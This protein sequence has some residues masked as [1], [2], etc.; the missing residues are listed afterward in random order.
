MPRPSPVRVPPRR[1]CTPPAGLAAAFAAAALAGCGASHQPELSQKPSFVGAVTTTTY[2]GSTDDLL[3]GGL[4]RVG[5][6][7]ANVPQV[8]TPPKASE[9]RRL[10][11]YTNYRALVDT[12]QAGGYGVL[13]GPNVDI[14]GVAGSSDGRIPGVEYRAY[15]DDGTGQRNV[16]MVTQV[17]GSFDTSAPCLLAVASPGSRG[18][19][20]GI[21]V[22]EWGL[23]HGCAVVL[24]D[25]GTGAA[26]HDLHGDTV[27][28]VDGTRESA[29]SAATAAAF[30][31]GLSATERASFDA[32]YPNR[33]AFKHAHSGRNPEKDWGRFV[34][35]GIKFGFW[36]MNQAMGPVTF[37]GEHE[38]R[39]KPDN[40]L[41]IAAGA[42]NAGGAALAAA[43][44]DTEGLIDGVAVSE[45]GVEMPANPGVTV[46]RGG[47]TI[48]TVAR[49]LYDFTSYANLYQA[50]ASQAAALASSPAISYVAAANAAARCNSLHANGLLASTTTAAQA[51]E[52][53]Q[54]L[55]DY[56]W[57]AE[58]DDLHASLAAFQ[59]APAVTVTF[60][61]ALA[62]AKVSDDLCGFSFGA[63]TGAGAPTTLDAATLGSM[64]GTGNGI[65]PT[66]GVQIINDRN[67][68]GP[69]SDPLSSSPSSGAADLNLDGALCLRSLLTGSDAPSQALQKGLDETRVT[70]H[71]NG[72]PV[73]IVHGRSDALLPV[74]HTSRPYAALATGA[75][76]GKLSYIEVTHA[77]HFDAFI[78]A[79]PGYD[80][81]Y[82][83]LHLYLARALDAV[84]ANLK[85]GTALPPSQVVRTIPRG[86]TAGA[87]PAI[88]ASAVPAIASAPAP[89]D[90]ITISG[91]TIHVPD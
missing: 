32:S 38:D 42:S 79:V 54:K 27:A 72:K 76:D 11:I 86:G 23:K 41:V 89:A 90:T 51:D 64:Y 6:L 91:S 17:P 74:N 29:A 77:Q 13:Y 48:A 47:T 84:Y 75:G 61:N 69:M 53:L 62:R 67:P 60:A 58:S 46:Q 44:Q 63:V 81:R 82:V 4:G 28:L 59:V 8:S 49:P 87:A 83:P 57:E 12:T 68:G 5:L 66:A 24:V 1:S 22:A 39:F 25:K 71:L 30:D 78:D 3:T 37:N 85:S 52:A 2:D 15:D 16:T 35:D 45:P 33:F 36:A 40:T 43:E 31:A 34:L 88:T 10:A 26:P 80:T 9:L 73:V 56:G 14:N 55:H 70:G 21:S 65:P 7:S 18:V 50:C 19:Y 20:G